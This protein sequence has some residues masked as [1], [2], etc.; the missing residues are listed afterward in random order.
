MGDVAASGGYYISCAADRIFAEPN[1]ITGSIGVFGILPN[2]QK[3]LNNKLGITID[4]VNTNKHAD[5]GS[6]YRPVTEA[7]REHILRGIQ[8]VY[9]DFISKVGAGRHMDTASIDAIGQGR[10]WSGTDA[11]NKGL[12]DE[13]GGIN[14]AI[15]YSAKLA[16]IDKYKIMELPQQKDP[17]SS[18]FSDMAGDEQ[19]RVMRSVLG[20]RYEQY[21]ELKALAQNKGV[22]ARMPYDVV[23]Y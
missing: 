11:K 7:E 6:V 10:V 20:D 2:F 8:Q 17:L 14:E 21:M 1:T 19:V 13:L 15:V 18:L 16:K 22:Q 23:F 12:V 5:L 3:L 9:N 4:T